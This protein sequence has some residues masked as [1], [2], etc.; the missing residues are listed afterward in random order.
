[1][2]W[3][4]GTIVWG[5]IWGFAT[6]EVIY[7]KGYKDNWFF[8]GFFFGVIAFIVAC[9]KQE[10]PK[11]DN[12]YYSYKDNL[13][14]LKGG[15]KINSQSSWV[16]G[17]CGTINESYTGTCRCGRT[18]DENIRM[19]KEKEAQRK[20]DE[21]RKIIELAKQQTQG[22]IMTESDRADAILKYKG[23]LDAG[24]ITEEEFDIKKKE[25]LGNMP[26]TLSNNTVVKS[27]DN[28]YNATEKTV[29]N[30]LEKH[31]EGV[32]GISI[33]QMVPRSID[34]KDI[35]EAIKNLVEI[36]IIGKNELG[37]YVKQ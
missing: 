28:N 9:C 27:L 19:A 14:F 33:S 20:L 31:P 5:I 32:S 6:R 10:Y 35:S 17:K 2:F 3:L 21:E 13:D 4:F 37:N 36:G 7:G 26:E 34:P 1:M 24:I 29:L 12:Y 16:C 25:L 18:K 11:S 22:K 15:N 8:W 23:L 30:L